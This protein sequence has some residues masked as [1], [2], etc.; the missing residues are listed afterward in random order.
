MWDKKVVQ[1]SLE[2]LESEDG[3]SNMPISVRDTSYAYVINNIAKRHGIES[4]RIALIIFDYKA[5]CAEEGDFNISGHSWS[6]DRDESS[7]SDP[8]WPG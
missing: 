4:T 8:P 5:I 7:A 2:D 1:Q 6:Y 3:V